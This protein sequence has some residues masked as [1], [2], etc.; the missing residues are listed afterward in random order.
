MHIITNKKNKQIEKKM[1]ETN[2]IKINR[3]NQEFFIN[4]VYSTD[5][6]PVQYIYNIY[7][8]F[9]KVLPCVFTLLRT[10]TVIHL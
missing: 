6:S 2:Q 4:K 5:I 8:F 1:N 9:L 3:P 10:K 7:I